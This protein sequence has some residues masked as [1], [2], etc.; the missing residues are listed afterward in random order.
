MYRD[1]RQRS[2][3]CLAF[4][5]SPSVPSPHRFLTGLVK[6]ADSKCLMPS[7]IFRLRPSCFQIWQKAS[8]IYEVLMLMKS[9]FKN[10]WNKPWKLLN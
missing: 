2:A 6:R 10:T 8:Y 5:S 7:R 4:S 1:V 9:S 3:K